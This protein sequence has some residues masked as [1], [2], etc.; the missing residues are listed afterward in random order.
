M[1]GEFFESEGPDAGDDISSTPQVPEEQIFGSSRNESGSAA[2]IESAADIS[3]GEDIEAELLERAEKIQTVD[4][5]PDIP[6]RFE[7]DVY[8]SEER[9][10]QAMKASFR[11]GS[12]AFSTSSVE[13]VSRAQWSFG[14][15]ADFADIV[16]FGKPDDEDFVQDND[17][18]PDGHPKAKRGDETPF[19]EGMPNQDEMEEIDAFLEDFQP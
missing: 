3:F 15:T 14:R 17:L 8:R 5:D 6:D 1:S 13:G 11:R 10:F 18:L 4:N 19:V 12:G 9:A 7:D 16:K 2:S